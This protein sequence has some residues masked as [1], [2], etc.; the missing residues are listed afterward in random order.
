MIK[1]ICFFL[2]NKFEC[3][4]IQMMIIMICLLEHLKQKQTTI[5]GYSNQTA[6]A[7]SY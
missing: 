7:D 4:R 5:N 2:S 6:I 1:N 3:S